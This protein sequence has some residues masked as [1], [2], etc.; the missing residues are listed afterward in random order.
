M[1]LKTENHKLPNHKNDRVAGKLVSKHP[2]TW[3]K[4]DRK[5]TSLGF[6]LLIS[7]WLP[8]TPWVKHE[9]NDHKIDYL[10]SSGSAVIQN[11]TC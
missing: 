2:V 3:L 10:I 4:N 11:Q 6:L 5:H 8:V 7:L 1:Q 9:K